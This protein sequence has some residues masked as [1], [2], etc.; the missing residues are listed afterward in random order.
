M[1]QPPN[2]VAVV[3]DILQGGDES[4]IFLIGSHTEYISIYREKEKE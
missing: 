1:F 2:V 3:L 4:N